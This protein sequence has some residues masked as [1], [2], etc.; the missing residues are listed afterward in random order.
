MHYIMDEVKTFL[1][2]YGIYLFFT[3]ILIG[4]LIAF[5]EDLKS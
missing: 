4:I 5:L 3:G 1:K 2:K